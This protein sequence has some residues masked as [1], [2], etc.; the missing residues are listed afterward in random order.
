M[1]AKLGLDEEYSV[2]VRMFAARPTWSIAWVSPSIV[3][4]SGARKWST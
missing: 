4:S 1:G 2:Y 3:D